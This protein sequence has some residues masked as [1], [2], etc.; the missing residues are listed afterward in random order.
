MYNFEHFTREDMYQCAIALRNINAGANSMEEIAQRM[1]QYLYD[2]IINLKT[3]ASACALVRFFRTYSYQNLNQDLQ[4][5]AVKILNNRYI[6]STVKCLTLLATVGD[7]P[8]W[9]SRQTSVGHQAIPLLDRNFVERAPMIFELIKQ[10]GLDVDAVLEPNPA[11]LMSMD[12]TTF[13]VFYV[14]DAVNSAFIPAQQEFVIPYG[15]KSVLGFGGIL[16][17]GNLFAIILFAKVSISP[18]T[19]NLFKWISAYARIAAASLNQERA[20]P[21]SKILIR[22]QI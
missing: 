1:V 9:N 13:S 17:C 21:N 18:D 14:P 10:F 2:N 16:P 7:E 19:A 22:P 5:S 8:Q 6:L 3:G 12:V 15:I 11:I 4:Q 20:L